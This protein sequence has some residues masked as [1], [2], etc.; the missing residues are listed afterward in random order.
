[1]VAV[2]AAPPQS[3]ISSAANVHGPE[4][5][6][7][8][9]LRTTLRELYAND[10]EAFNRVFVACASLHEDGP[11]FDRVNDAPVDLV[12]RSNDPSARNHFEQELA[13]FETYRAQANGFQSQGQQRQAFQMP[14]PLKSGMTAL[15][16][17]SARGRTLPHSPPQDS[18]HGTEDGN[19]DGASS[20]HDS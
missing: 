15:T 7:L 13:V 17:S 8:A 12:S 5:P 11:A 16:N 6:T 2:S 4:H 19:L 18:Q 10:L 9:Q 3:A 1:M 14:Y 20:D